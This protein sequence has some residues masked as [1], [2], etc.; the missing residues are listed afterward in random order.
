MWRTVSATTLEGV[1]VYRIEVEWDGWKP[2]TIKIQPP[3]SHS[4][5]YTNTELVLTGVGLGVVYLA[6]HAFGIL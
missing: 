2:K 4:S 6:L 1:S 5:Q 3:P